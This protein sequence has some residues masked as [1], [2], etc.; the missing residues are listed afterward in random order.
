MRNQNPTTNRNKTAGQAAVIPTK[1]QKEVTRYFDFTNKILNGLEQVI[2]GKR[3]VLE[4]LITGLVA[5]GHVLIEDVPGLGKTTMAKTLAHLISKSKNKN[6]VVFKRIQFTPDLLPYDITGV[7]VFDP[8]HKKFTFLPGPVFAN[9]VLADEIN[10][11]TPKVQSALLEVMAERQ[12]TVGNVTHIMDKLF[13][14]IATQNPVE[15]EGTYPLPVAQIDRFIMKLRIGYPSAEVEENIVIDE[16]ATRILPNIK[17]ICGQDDILAFQHF[18]QQVYCD[19]KLIQAAVSLSQSTRTHR[20]IELGTSPRASIMLV[21]AAK[22]YAV[23]QNRG[24]VIDQDIIDLAPLVMGHRIK[25]KDI[26]INPE[27]LIREMT[28]NTLSRINY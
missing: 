22:T 23:I 4:F 9:I 6:P 13:F 21:R 28:L 16:P 1:L 3:K 15:T 17:P 19:H 24:Y 10:R 8:V 20:G 11:T 12:V 2:R 26:R 27:S 18:I 5:G 25:L 14:V 7:D